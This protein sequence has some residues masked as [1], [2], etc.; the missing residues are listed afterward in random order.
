MSNGVLCLFV[1][2]ELAAV[3]RAPERVR[4]LGEHELRDDRARDDDAKNRNGFP[5]PRS[6]RRVQDAEPLASVLQ[7]LVITRPRIAKLTRSI[8]PLNTL[9]VTA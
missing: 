9:G 7:P 2:P 4:A 8:D 1:F 3:R 5:S 6:F